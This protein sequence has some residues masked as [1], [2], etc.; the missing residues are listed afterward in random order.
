LFGHEKGSFTDATARRVGQFELAN[1]GTIFLDEVGELSLPMQAKLLRVLETGDFQRVGETQVRFSKA[2]IVAATNRDLREEA[3]AGRF[4]ADLYHR[5]SVFSIDMPPLRELGDDRL[6]LLAHFRSQY[7]KQMQYQPFGLAPDAEAAWLA[8]PFPGNVRELRNIVIRLVT[9]YPGQ[10]LAA[11][12]VCAEFDVGALAGGQ[13]AAETADDLIAAA[14]RELQYGGEFNLD[15]TLK[16]WENRYIEAALRLSRGNV[17]QAA[18]LLGINRTTLY[19]RLG[20]D[21]K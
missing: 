16:A 2:R 10:T 8:Y 14:M 11:V 7:C 6:A 20:P 9:K 5:L 1:S 15:Q 21:F 3:R 4:R 19:G 18:K 12:T 17:S 13:Q